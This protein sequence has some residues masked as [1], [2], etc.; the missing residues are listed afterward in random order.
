MAPTV[1]MMLSKILPFVIEEP[2]QR[3]MIPLKRVAM[4]SRADIP[5]VG[6]INVYNTH[7]CAFCDPE[8]RLGQAT[9][10]AVAIT[11]EG[12]RPLPVEIQALVSKGSEE[13]PR[14]TGRAAPP[15]RWPPC[16]P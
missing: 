7:L 9:G 16:R 12:T 11:M 6:Q 4:M 3:W 13:R 14:R 1:P 10:S 2:F 8:E 5:G 15:L